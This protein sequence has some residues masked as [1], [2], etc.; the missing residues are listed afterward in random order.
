M[1]MNLDLLDELDYIGTP[2][3]KT[4]AEMKLID[5]FM[6][7]SRFNKTKLETESEYNQV[8][9]HLEFLHDEEPTKVDLI[10]KLETLVNDYQKTN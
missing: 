1:Q 10:K 3:R 8:M 5:V 6:W 9:R 4:E 7:L 2:R